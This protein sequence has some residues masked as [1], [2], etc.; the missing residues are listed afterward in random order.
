MIEIRIDGADTVAQVL[1]G[2][3]AAVDPALRATGDELFGR[4][5]E[6][7]DKHTKTGAMARSLK[8]SY[9][10]GEYRIWHDLQHAP[11]AAFVHWGTRPHKIS[12]KNRKALRFPVGGKFVFAKWVNHPGYKGDPYFVTEAKPDDVLRTFVRFFNQEVARSA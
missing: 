2:T 3:L 1:H 11:H 7:A 4:I 8:N 6:A 10:A 5:W 12:A 9:S